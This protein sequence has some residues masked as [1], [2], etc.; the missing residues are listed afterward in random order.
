MGDVIAVIIVIVVIYFLFTK[1]LIPFYMLLA[2]ILGRAVES[3]ADFFQWT[4]WATP[5]GNLIVASLAL[6][7]A[8]LILYPIYKRL[9]AGLGRGRIY[10][11]ATVESVL[12]H[13]ISEYRNKEARPLSFDSGPRAAFLI[14]RIIVIVAAIAATLATALI[15]ARRGTLMAPL[16]LS[17]LA[18]G[19]GMTLFMGI[20]FTIE[21][22]KACP[23][24]RDNTSE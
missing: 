13:S 15:H 19:A 8:A 17:T 11:K 7:A 1:L 18:L 4:L 14:L 24:G 23:K 12:A 22:R 20:S 5:V 16:T 10:D 9:A 2:G 21:A 6:L 3:V